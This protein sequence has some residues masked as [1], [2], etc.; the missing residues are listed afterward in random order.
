MPDNSSS[1]LA[2]VTLLYVLAGNEPDLFPS[3]FNITVTP[4]QL[5]GTCIPRPDRLIS[6][7][8]R[9]PHLPDGA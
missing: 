2:S 4:Q 3:T 9:L 7:P 8:S 5:A 6:F 1:S